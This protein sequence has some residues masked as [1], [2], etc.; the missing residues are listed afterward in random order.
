V[1]S[2]AIG[3]ALAV[4]ALAAGFLG[5]G[6]RG[7]V[8]A[9][10]VI[11]FWLLLQFSRT[12]RV[13]RNAAGSPVGH[14]ASAVTLQSKLQVGAPLSAVIGLARSLGRKV[15][16]EPQTFAWRDAGGVEVEVE[17]E[18]G[19]CRRWVLNRPADAE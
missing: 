14:V 7:L 4:A 5:Y 12:M 15:R 2:A 18:R 8:L 3:W 9:L 10:S 13:L 1:S 17:F 11:V 16:D 6:W 19:R